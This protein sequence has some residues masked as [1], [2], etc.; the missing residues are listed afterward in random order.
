MGAQPVDR[1]GDSES[2][3]G[4]RGSPDGALPSS[5]T[6]GTPCCGFHVKADLLPDYVPASFPQSG[7]RV[8]GW[9]RGVSA[10]RMMAR[11][12]QDGQDDSPIKRRAW[13]C[14]LW[15]DASAGGEDKYVNKSP[16][17]A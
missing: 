2:E 13:T 8:R 5:L 10:E 3:M 15:R 6:P 4:L 14:V 17:P 11:N 7:R 16:M 12:F 1:N 9:R